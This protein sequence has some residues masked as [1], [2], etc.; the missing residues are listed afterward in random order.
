VT[1]FETPPGPSKMR[2]F[3]PMRGRHDLRRFGSKSMSDNTEHEVIELGK[4]DELVYAIYY[5]AY[6]HEW[7]RFPIKIGSTTGPLPARLRAYSTALPERPRVA[8]LIHTNRASTLE[9][10]LHYVLRYRGQSHEEAGGN[11]WFMTTPDEIAF[12]YEFL[13]DDWENHGFFRG[14]YE[15]SPDHL[16]PR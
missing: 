10:A 15:P 16:T 2:G 12:L 4:G 3:L 11:E 9:L 14:D 1:E 7:E 8:V 6:W 13:A 5:P